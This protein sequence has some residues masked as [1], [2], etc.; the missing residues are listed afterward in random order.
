MLLIEYYAEWN[1][2]PVG[3]LRDKEKLFP[4]PETWPRFLNFQA[5]IVAAT[6]TALSRF[7][8]RVIRRENVANTAN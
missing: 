5:C 7:P 8:F 4:L 1:A 2:E 6:P 3:A